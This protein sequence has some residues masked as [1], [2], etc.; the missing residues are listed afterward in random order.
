MKK[1][2][3]KS[4][5]AYVA[6]VLVGYGLLELLIYIIFPFWKA[7]SGDLALSVLVLT[8]A[9]ACLE[10]KRQ[11]L[12]RT[13]FMAVLLMAPAFVGLLAK[14]PLPIA[15]Q[16]RTI[17]FSL[18]FSGAFFFLQ[19]ILPFRKIRIGISA[20]FYLIA[21]LL[22]LLPW[23]YFF[24]SH[25][26][27]NA[28]AVL[29][30]FQTNP[31]EAKSYL[32]DFMPWQAW[33]IMAVLLAA[34]VFLLRQWRPSLLS[35]RTSLQNR[36]GILLIMFCIVLTSYS[37]YRTRDSF[38]K[39]L[40]WESQRGLQ[41][42]RDFSLYRRVRASSLKEDLSGINKGHS[43]VYVLVIGESQNRMHM[44]AY[45]YNQETTPWLDRMK[46]DSHTVFFTDARSCHTHTVP[47]LSYALTA[48]NQ[49]DHRDLAKA[50]TLI[51]AAKA[52]GYKTV[53]LSNQVRYGAWDTP[54]S[55]IASE[56]DQQEWLN[57]HVGETTETAVYDGA[58][59]DRLAEVKPSDK[60]LIVIHLMGNHGS[61]ID[62]YPQDFA[63]EKG[64]T[65][66][67]D[68][69]ILYNDY[70]VQHIYDTA[71]QMLNFQGMVYFADHADDVD[72]NIGHDASR[73]TQDMTRIPFYMI[74]SDDYMKDYP[75]AV[76][77]L[78]AH[79]TSGF[80]NDLIYNTMLAVMGVV[81]PR[82]YEEQNDL[83]CPEYNNDKTR[84]RTLHGQQELD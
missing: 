40:A 17:A 53:W 21:F 55:A 70:V 50:T 44:S 3:G 43:G 79:A 1:W 54:T 16:Y 20:V 77:E 47:V 68:N 36:W 72:R 14:Q 28:S 35:M 9:S 7:K 60:M 27:L 26:L 29:A 57:T 71:K 41:A 80:T 67:Y 51:E 5:M 6:E 83:T 22:F 39:H 59:A 13:L 64:P 33:G 15:M 76:R 45:G 10:K 66:E 46:N 37:L 63:V 32:V 31:A 65:A 11:F 30:V 48:K 75:G 78:R 84:F 38:Y 56:A 12:L 24:A 69:S 58:L 61:Y 2:W 18:I 49:Y 82:D 81:I 19:A 34:Y 73:F 23:G 4:V 74:F 62:R 42:Y 8:F 52:A 25:S